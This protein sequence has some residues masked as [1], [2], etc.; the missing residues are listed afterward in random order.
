MECLVRSGSKS[1]IRFGSGITRAVV[2]VAV[3]INQHLERGVLMS[4]N[5]DAISVEP[6]FCAPRAKVE[7]QTLFARFIKLCAATYPTSS[8]F[9]P[10]GNFLG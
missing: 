9:T 7:L 2:A 8:A 1:G 3:V 6:R 5:Q 4:Y 10:S